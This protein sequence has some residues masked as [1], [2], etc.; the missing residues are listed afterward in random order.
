MILR[1]HDPHGYMVQ[2][3]T[4]PQMA[5]RKAGDAWVITGTSPRDALLE[6]EMLLKADALRQMDGFPRYVPDVKAKTLS[7]NLNMSS[8]ESFA[9]S[10]IDTSTPGSIAVE[11]YSAD[12]YLN[13][14]VV[15][16][17]QW[18][19]R[20]SGI[21]RMLYRSWKTPLSSEKL[22]EPYAEPVLVL[23]PAGTMPYIKDYRPK[24][25]SFPQRD[26]PLPHHL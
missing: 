17:F 8:N 13:G 6:V 7:A 3:F 18:N 21:Y 25:G 26:I 24:P 15:E 16:R 5:M 1:V 9:K 11:N 14:T 2:L 22:S 10:A 19:I 4:H 12:I 20:H 23:A